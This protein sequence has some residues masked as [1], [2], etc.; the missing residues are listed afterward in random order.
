MCLRNL[1]GIGGALIFFAAC[2]SSENNIL[3]EELA[4]A[5]KFNPETYICYQSSG[6]IVV[7]GK[8]DEDDWEAAAWTNIFVDIEGD[9]KPMPTYPTRAK[10]LWDSVYFYI[11]A[12]LVEPH[13]WGTLQQRDTVIFYDNDFEIFIDP[14]WDT[15]HYYEFEMNALNTF[16]DLLLTKPYRDDGVPIDN[17]NITGLKTGVYISGTMNDPSDMDD[18]WTVEVAMPM[19]VLREAQAGQNLPVDGEQWRVGFSRVEWKMKHENGAYK[20]ETGPQG[21][22][23]PEDN[24]VWSAT[25]EIDMHKPELWGVVQFSESN[26]DK[27]NA[28]YQQDK[29]WQI[30][31]QLRN[32]Y[33]RQQNYRKTFNTFASSADELRFDDF[34]P[35]MVVHRNT[36]TASQLSS[37]GKFYWLIREDGRLWKEQK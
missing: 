32:L 30:I 15:H 23:I 33:Y 26:T 31:S 7:D 9:K 18:Y 36:Y 28:V 3:P 1:L 34:N 5:Q 12:E 35:A 27:Q 13:I 2:S 24:W 25:D 16:W 17:W 19:D 14:D 22:R 10:M 29:D 37:T 21:E 11:A 4:V 8:M 6:E 20:K